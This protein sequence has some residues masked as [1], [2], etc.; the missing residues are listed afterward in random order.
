[1]WSNLPFDLLANIFSF[2]SPDSLACA[3]SSCRH[4]HQCARY[5][6]T[7]ES[8]RRHPPWFIAL[9]NRSRGLF[10][11]AYNPI[12]DSN[13]S[14]SWYMLPLDFLPIP[15]RPVSATAG[16]VLLRSTSTTPFQLAICNPFTRQFRH[17]PTLNVTRI[18]PAVGVIELDPG[19]QF[20]ELNFRAYVAGGMSEAPGGGAL[21]EPKVEMYDSRCDTWKVIGSMPVEF[22]VR[23]TVWT[24]SESVYSNGILYWMT[25]ARAYSVMGFEIATN[26]WRE[27][28]VPVADRLEFA[29]LV[30]RNGKLTLLG[31][32]CGG[33]ACIW[34]LGE[35][36]VWRMIEKVPFELG[37]RFLGG[38]GCWDSTKCVGNNGI[39]CLYKDLGSG[40]LV[41]RE[42]V[43]EGRWE[44][45]WIDGC[46]SIRGQQLQNFQIKG[47]LLHPNL[48]HSSL[49]NA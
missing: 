32:K 2:L 1:M 44:W 47:L 42:V 20:G 30:Q 10:C 36:D 3:K 45:F 38:K 17:L 35:G 11:C 14:S 23:L 26:S 16:L 7:P 37:M 31:G 29:A 22:A 49:L 43:D 39:V 9:P 13:S 33:D 6:A 5:L 8:Q 40:M 19:H 12:D 21:Y 46:C 15:T 28:S 34:E 4:W 18:N 25:S 24:P 27:L 48:A 41:W